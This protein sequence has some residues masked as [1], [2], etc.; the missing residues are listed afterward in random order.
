MTSVQRAL[1]VGAGSIGSR[2]LENLRALGV[3]ALGLVEPFS[4]RREAVSRQCSAVA[5]A[6]L[7]QGLA[8]RPDIVVIATPTQL[9]VAQALDVA[10][11]AV[12]VF[13]EKP[14]SH[15]P[16]RIRDVLG[17]VGGR[18][19]ISMVGCNMRFHPGPAK[20][21][22]LLE[23][24][25]IGRVLFARVHTGSYLPDWR[26]A[27][28][29][30]QSYSASDAGG[31]ILDCIHEIDLARWYMGEVTEVTALAA[32][33]SR[34]E[35]AS[36][37]VAA[38]LFRHAGGG[39]SEVHLD[40]AQRTYERG[41]HIAGEAGSIFWDF[42][43]GRVRL[44]QAPTGRETIF[45]QPRNWTVNQMYLDEMRHFLVCVRD[46][47]PTIF[48]VEEGARV[49]R[50]ALAAKQSAGNLVRLGAEVMTA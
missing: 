30:R 10:R 40:F 21:K 24:Q 23:Q 38:M 27:Q 1:V 39:I 32:H 49:L 19:L 33:L 29:Y 45:D 2:H 37:D 3:P 28:D 7:E 6:S 17:E 26:P 35:V 42:S 25:S 5:F 31:C 4:E 9:H 34:L 50:I 44:F 12:P 41:C 48:P 18:G 36:E 16:E 47:K 46:G 22:E 43:A 20:I 13:V 11:A 8:W 15:T 14:L